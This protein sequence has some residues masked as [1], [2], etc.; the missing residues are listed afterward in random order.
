MKQIVCTALLLSLAFSLL[1]TAKNAGAENTCQQTTPKIFFS[2]IAWAGSSK[3][4]ADEWLELTNLEIEAVDLS[5][6]TISGAATSGGTLTLPNNSLI[7]PNSV[8][9]IANYSA[10]NTS[11]ALASPPDYVTTA[12]SLS[13]SNL[14]L[15]LR[16]KDGC[17]IDQAGDGKAPFFGGTST[18]GTISMFRFQ[19]ITDGT[20]SSSWLAAESSFG[21]D[22]GTPDLGTPGVFDYN[23][24]IQNPIPTENNAEDQTSG[25]ENEIVSETSKTETNQQLISEPAI[26]TV[27][28]TP[29]NNTQVVP[30]ENQTNLGNISEE[31]NSL[32]NYTGSGTTEV[33]E[34]TTSVGS[35]VTTSGADQTMETSGAT[36]ATETATLAETTILDNTTSTVADVAEEITSV[37]TPKTITKIATGQPA[38][39]NVVDSTAISTTISATAD[40]ES[41]D[42]QKTMVSTITDTKIFDQDKITADEESAGGPKQVATDTDEENTTVSETATPT[43]T[44]DEPTPLTDD[45]VTPITSNEEVQVVIN[46]E[47]NSGQK[48][49]SETSSTT[50]NISYPLGTLLI[51]EFVSDPIKG[52]KEWVEIVNP[53]NTVISLDDWEISESSGRKSALPN[54]TL[55]YNQVAVAEFSSGALNNDTDTIT[56][57]DPNGEIIDQIVYGTNSVPAAN[58]PNSMAKDESGKFV[59]TTTPTKNSFNTIIPLAEETAASNGENDSASDGQEDAITVNGDADSTAAAE[60]SSNSTSTEETAA[61]L[62]EDSALTNETNR[63]TTDSTRETTSATEEKPNL[64]LSEL[65]PNT[66]G[67]DATDEFIEIEN[68]GTTAIDLFGLKLEDAAKNSW[69]FPNHTTLEAN[70]FLAISRTDYQ[71]ALNNSG[72]ETVNLY[73]ANG[74]LLD[75][76]QYE[77]APKKFTFS[78]ENDIWRWTNLL[79]SNEPNVF[80]ET[81]AAENPTVVSGNSSNANTNDTEVV[82]RTATTKSPARVSLAEARAMA[83]DNKVIVD[84]IVTAEPGTLGSQIFYITDGQTGIQIY[85]SDGNFPDLNIGDRVEISGT[86]SSNR[87]EPRIKIG[88][89]DTITV[90]EENVPLA[91]V[92]AETIDESLAGN[93]V[94]LSG[95][96]VE[97]SSGDLTVENTSGM[98]EVKIKDSTG[99]ALTNFKPG[100]LVSAT[101]LVGQ[102]TDRFYLLPRS[103]DDLVKETTENNQTQATSPA[104]ST[105]KQTMAQNNQRNAII[106][107]AAVIIG[108]VIYALRKKIVGLKKI[109]EK[110]DKLS[111]A[112][113][114]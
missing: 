75:S 68:F 111:L 57:L 29:T 51:N 13:N 82:E 98:A 34:T 72:S 110:R 71:F 42:V 95:T 107:G 64:R 84:G 46:N 76:I 66:G 67:A 35:E 58:D 90:L 38:Q 17:F 88:S 63:E 26:E 30:T 31:E 97:K 106:I 113:A 44:A 104:E 28:E 87:S 18:T 81:T 4:T 21:F 70:R 65:Y 60:T 56:L 54:T 33:S 2:E 41:P 85:K 93:L 47:T 24:V 101:G 48:T 103:P 59:V 74:Q 16:N 108:L 15:I 10:E 5:G 22:S 32:N 36:M 11:S 73:S 78:R 45:E 43:T 62:S 109:Y 40:E 89:T 50:T 39:E 49:T 55:R 25:Q 23:L 99:I 105:G 53:N 9:L 37:Y 77:N 102:T 69:V 6:W 20:I 100:D 86:T 112:P 96:I 12:V 83:R 92:E 80:P 8:Y 91:V 1:R 3:S 94:H 61:V 19:P 79:T 14:G 114:R 7:L 27:S 52:E